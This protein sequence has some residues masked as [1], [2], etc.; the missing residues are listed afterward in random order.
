MFMF[1]FAKTQILF[2]EKGKSKKKYQEMI[3]ML[4]EGCVPPS[5]YKYICKAEN[6]IFLNSKNVLYSKKSEIFWSFIRENLDNHRNMRS[7]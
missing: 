4:W 2:L 5:F 3:Y 6:L 7:I 1:C